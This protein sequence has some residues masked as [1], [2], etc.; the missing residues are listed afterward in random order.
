MI[1]YAQY[2][3]LVAGQYNH[4]Q[5][6]IQGGYPDSGQHPAGVPITHPSQ[7]HLHFHTQTSPIS[8]SQPQTSQNHAHAIQQNYQSRYVQSNIHYGITGITPQAAAIAATAVTSGQGG[9][10]YNLRD[11][12]LLQ[13]SP[14][15]QDV[16]VKKERGPGSP[17]QMNNQINHGRPMSQ[18]AVSPV[19]PNSQPLMNHGAPHSTVAP[20]PTN[21]QHPQSPKLVSDTVEE[22]PLYVNAKQFHRI[23]KR[24]VARQRLEEVLKITTKIRKPYLHE[25]RHNHTIRRPRG[26]NGRFLSADEITKIGTTKEDGYKEGDKSEKMPKKGMS[27]GTEGSDKKR[28][29]DTDSK[30]I[31]MRRVD[32]E[33]WSLK[34]S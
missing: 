21:Q 19:L 2:Q 23:L 25:S 6:H 28:K 8:S 5:R 27:S 4:S 3:K 20:M 22:S 7:Q 15:F 29:A 14:R 12:G 18:Q 30:P 34:L 11:S 1:M 9:Y 10:P 26:P 13:T 24:R 17:Q 31:K 16:A 33:K 32:I